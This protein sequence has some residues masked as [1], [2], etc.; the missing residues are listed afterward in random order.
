MTTPAKKMSCAPPGAPA[1]NPLGFAPADAHNP[2][3]EGRP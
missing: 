2:G 1:Q 3:S